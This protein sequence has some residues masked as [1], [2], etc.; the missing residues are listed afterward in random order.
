MWQI[1][2]MLNLIPDNFLLWIYYFILSA[3]IILLSVGWLI[4]WF[5]GVAVYK[6]PMQLLGVVLTAGSLYLLGGH[7]TEMAWRD[8][9]R[10]LEEKVKIAEQQAAEANTKVEVQIVEKTKVIKEKGNTI[11]KY[12]D[13]YNDRE[14]IKT[15][16]GPER[17]RIE[18]VIKYIEKC[19]V[20]KEM[21]DIHNQAVDMNKAAEGAKK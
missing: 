4:K 11:V 14:V 16:E 18:E 17:V 21:I 19:P 6:G 7:G 10:A 5:P 15:V 12:I 20:P 1:Q 2:W 8:K 9:V 13:R 3:G